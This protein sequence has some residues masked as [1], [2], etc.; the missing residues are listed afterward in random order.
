MS[1]TQPKAR[2]VLISGAGIGGPALA[3]W[4]RRY[5]FTPTI[6]ER[7]PVLR[8]G[9][10]KIDL[11]GTAIDVAERMGIIDDVRRAHTDMRSA[12]FLGKGGK[13]IATL[14][15]QLFGFREP[16]DVEI[17]LG[18]LKRILHDATKHDVEYVFDD[19]ITSIA[20]QEGRVTVSFERNASRE[21]DLVVG[22]DGARSNVRSLVFGDEAE[23]TK[24]F[25]CYAAICTVPNFLALD[26]TELVYASVGATTNVYSTRG[27]KAARALFVFSSPPLE[28]NR[29]DQTQQ[30]RI[31]TDRFACESWEVPRLLAAMQS[32]PDFYFDAV[33]QIQMERWSKGRVVLLGDAGYGPSLASGQGTSQA[34]VGAY[35]LAGELAAAG[36][37]HEAAFSAYEREMRGFVAKNQRLGREGIDNMVV[38]SR[39]QLFTMGLGLRMLRFMPG[40][41][42]KR[43]KR[44]VEETART[45]TLKDYPSLAQA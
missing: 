45:V 24:P 5:G 1:N 32:A 39:W 20:E 41:F 6:V 37:E 13:P 10:Y 23:F 3:W 29:R 8:E 22:A 4:L 38:R 21:F 35:V 28:Y 7:A 11:R 19:S 31:V 36:G 15:S 43:F 25:G 44:T 18:T 30:R 16:R 12:T 2:R 26:R 40:A 17:M 14:D 34:M 33:G 42:V 27:D 9:G